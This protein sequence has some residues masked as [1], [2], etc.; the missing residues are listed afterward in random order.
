MKEYLLGLISQGKT[1]E[2]LQELLRLTSQLENK[3]YYEEA[4]AQSARYESYL[5]GSRLGT[6]SD[7]DNNISLAQINQALIELIQQLP[8]SEQE[9]KSSAET[10][11]QDDA[12]FLNNT[13]PAKRILK[14]IG[15][16]GVILA[17]PA[18][19][20]QISG[21]SLKDIFNDEEEPSSFFV[22]VIVHGKKGKNDRVL[23]NQGTVILDF[24]MIRE[25]AINVKGEATFKGL[26]MGFIG[27]EAFISIDHPKR[28]VP[29]DKD[30]VYLLEKGK[31]IYLE[32]EKDI[33]KGSD[34]FSGN[35]TGTVQ[36]SAGKKLF[37]V[38]I[39]CSNCM[40]QEPVFSNRNGYFELPIRVK[41]EN[42]SIQDV[43][44]HFQYNGLNLIE[45]VNI[46]YLDSYTPPIF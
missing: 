9:R 4:V 21:Y 27:K 17:I 23:R 28:Y 46:D 1:K 24:G 6:I 22:K 12:T 5:K 20:V 26:P 45:N 31:S 42:H 32:V 3:S 39:Q 36:D 16:I 15:M 7:R 25:E 8:D 37:N 43:K 11:E 34:I 10:T 44:I 35:L 19:I 13:S 41:K 30:T 18:A 14:W 40:G 2:T 29:T 33:E 38:R